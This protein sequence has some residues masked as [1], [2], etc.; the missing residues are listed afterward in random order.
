MSVPS[1]GSLAGGIG[2][3]RL[4]NQYGGLAGDVGEVQSAGPA[5]GFGGDGL[6]GGLVALVSGQDCE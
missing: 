5:V 4:V 6:G 2:D 1:G 3:L